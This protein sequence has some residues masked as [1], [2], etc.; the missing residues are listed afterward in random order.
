MVVLGDAQQK[1]AFAMCVITV[2]VYTMATIFRFVATHCFGRKPG[3]EDWFALAAPVTFLPHAI[4]LLYVTV[5]IHGR[6]TPVLLLAT[7]SQ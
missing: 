7:V 1:A 2:P 6:P 4:A 3:L 5:N